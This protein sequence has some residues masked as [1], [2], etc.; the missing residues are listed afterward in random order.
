MSFDDDTTEL[1]ICKYISLHGD[2]EC[3]WYSLRRLHSVFSQG[4]SILGEEEQVTLRSR[5][6][7]L[8]IEV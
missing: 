4:S 5:E 7:R 2:D 1:C 8:D 6:T 3:V